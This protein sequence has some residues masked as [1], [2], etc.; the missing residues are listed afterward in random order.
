MSLRDIAPARQT[1]KFS[2]DGSVNLVN[3]EV[4]ADASDSPLP[5]ANYACNRVCDNGENPGNS[6]FTNIG[7]SHCRSTLACDVR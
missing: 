7:G 1:I 2:P 6:D 4:N 3:R 5:D